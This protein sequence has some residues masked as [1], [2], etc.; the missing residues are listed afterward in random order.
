MDDRYASLN[1]QAAGSFSV[2]WYCMHSQHSVTY[3][4]HNCPPVEKKADRK[5]DLR[6]HEKQSLR[7]VSPSASQLD[8]RTDTSLS[9]PSPER[10]LAGLRIPWGVEVSRNRTMCELLRTLAEIHCLHAEVRLGLCGY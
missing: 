8:H 1:F 10:Q 4:N 6:L 9:K 3:L 2:L 7:G 5:S